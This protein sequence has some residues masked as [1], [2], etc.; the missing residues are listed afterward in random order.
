MTGLL[1]EQLRSAIPLAARMRFVTW[2]TRRSWVPM[3]D[4]MA[5]GLVR[6]LLARDPKQFHKFA[7]ANHL[8]AYARWYDS[9]DELFAFEQM[10]PTRIEL[11]RD[12]V[13]ALEEQ[14]VRP[15]EV[16]S[17]LEVGCSLGYLL[18]YAEL[19]V[20][21]D[22]TDIVGIDIDAEAIRKGQQVLARAGSR[23]VLRAGDMEQLESLVGPRGFDV[24][25]GAGVL[26]YLN[27][28]DA[29]RMVEQ[30]LSRTRK[31]LALAGLACVE[32]NNNCLTRSAPSPGHAGQWIHNFEALVARAGGRVVRTRWDP[33]QYNF[34]TICFVFAVPAS[35]VDAGTR[36]PGSAW[37]QQ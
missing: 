8:M 7:W 2:L 18:R 26:S 13:A 19:N 36:A 12:L 5:M 30:L 37:P 9:E 4:R 35:H 25:L 32:R 14:N 15:S 10:Q 6:D 16:R 3:R 17:F 27:E 28:A 24:T 34:Q 11:F 1:K 29:L 22:C 31:V 23:V 20:F 21:P 33:K